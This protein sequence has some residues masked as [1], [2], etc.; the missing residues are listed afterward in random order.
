MGLCVCVCVCVCVLTIT[1]GLSLKDAQTK[2]DHVGTQPQGR[3][4][5]KNDHIGTLPQGRAN[6]KKKLE[7]IIK[8]KDLYA[9]YVYI[10]V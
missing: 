9:K 1:S 4:N 10:Y 8:H 6:V 7:R 2:I 5:V 3:A